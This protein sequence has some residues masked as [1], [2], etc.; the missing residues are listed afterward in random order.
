MRSI[1]VPEYEIHD[2]VCVDPAK[3][4]LVVVEERDEGHL[5]PGHS[6]RG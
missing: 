1:E 4:A 6:R 2:E 5:Y 3:T